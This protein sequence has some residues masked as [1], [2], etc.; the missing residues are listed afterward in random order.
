MVPPSVVE[1][2]PATAAMAWAPAPMP[3][4]MVGT[5]A[6][7][8]SVLISC[9]RFAGRKKAGDCRNQRG[10]TRTA[11]WWLRPLRVVRWREEWRKGKGLRCRDVERWVANM[12]RPAG[13]NPR[14][15]EHA[16]ERGSQGA[17]RVRGEEDSPNEQTRRS[18]VGRFERQH[19]LRTLGDTRPPLNTLGP[20][21]CSGGDY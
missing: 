19:G 13:K 14:F 1:M 11:I 21:S 16:L 3:P 18:G 2:V 9:R 8:S 20:A 17:R 10:T 15:V 12:S 7:V 6:E 5:S 4:G